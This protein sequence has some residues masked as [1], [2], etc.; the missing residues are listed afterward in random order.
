METWGEE[1]SAEGKPL[2]G[3]WLSGCWRRKPQLSTIQSPLG[4]APTVSVRT[5]APPDWGEPALLAFSL[6]CERGPTW[7]WA[8]PLESGPGGRAR[9]FPV[10]VLP[11]PLPR[12]RASPSPLANLPWEPRPWPQ[13]L[14][15]VT[16]GFSGKKFRSL[17]SPDLR[18][19]NSS[20][21]SW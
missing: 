21:W 5:H 20:S 4:G 9:G 15:H 13:Q 17:P 2:S 3:P 16:S 8:W 1:F 10:W 12:C 11:S 14:T 7:P 6:A 19:G 18:N